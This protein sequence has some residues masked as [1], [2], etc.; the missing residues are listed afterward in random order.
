M[1]EQK[2]FVLVSIMENALMGHWSFRAPDELAV[3]RYLLGH[4]WEYQDVFWALR[5]SPDEVESLSPEELLQAIH[6]SYPN[7]HVR[8]VL[9]LLPIGPTAVCTPAESTIMGD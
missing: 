7:Q 3:A 1:R 4:L 9:Y 2:Q 8:A 6:D 5:I